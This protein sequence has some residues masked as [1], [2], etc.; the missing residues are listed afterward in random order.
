M[1]F[2]GGHLGVRVSA[3]VD[4]QLSAQEADRAWAHVVACCSCREAVERE[5]WVKD[6]ILLMG[7]ETPP[8]GL[9]HALAELAAAPQPDVVAEAWAA[10]GALERRHRVRRAGVIVAG[11]SLSVAVL[12]VVAVGALSTG[13]ER[14]TP[15]EAQ[16]SGGV[17]PAADPASADRRTP[18]PATRAV[19]RL[20]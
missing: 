1:R 7:A 11:G 5:T 13:T 9:S 10:V 15:R 2:V 18:A 3:L 12:S 6:R 16:V 19:L 14:P 20:P 17:S 4:G 8:S